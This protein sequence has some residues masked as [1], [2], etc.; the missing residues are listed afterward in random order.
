MA[1]TVSIVYQAR[2]G[3]IAS[4]APL[5]LAPIIVTGIDKGAVLCHCPNCRKASGSSFAHNYRLTKASLSIPQGA[6]L[7]RTYADSATKTGNTLQR[8]FCGQCGSPLYMEN[9]A[10]PGLVILHAG[11]M[12]DGTQQ[13]SLE[14]FA[15]DKYSWVGDVT[16]KGAK[17]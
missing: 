14:L 11:S 6:A 8:H 17:L 16:G 1:Y 2:V 7:V 15:E 13:P 10:F 9:A 4:Q 5:Y 3:D 12:Q